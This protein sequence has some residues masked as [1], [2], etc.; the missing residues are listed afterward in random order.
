VTDVPVA[1]RPVRLSVYDF[2]RSNEQG[3]VETLTKRSG[4][5]WIEMIR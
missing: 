5:M 4:W 2:I 3:V 1:I